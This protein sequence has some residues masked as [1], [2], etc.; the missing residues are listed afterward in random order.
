MS[1]V[2]VRP[3]QRVLFVVEYTKATFM[4]FKH[5]V[6]EILPETSTTA[7][8]TSMTWLETCRREKRC[9]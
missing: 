3:R 9:F 8:T 2:V 6:K 1:R 5:H 4:S 7:V